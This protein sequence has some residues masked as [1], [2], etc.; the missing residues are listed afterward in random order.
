MKW[1]LGI[2]IGGEHLR[3]AVGCAEGEPLRAVRCDPLSAQPGVGR[4]QQQ[5]AEGVNS[6]L[7][8][9][10]VTREQ[11]AG[12]GVAAVGLVDLAKGVIPTGSG[13][14]GGGL[15]PIVDWV[16]KEFSWSAVLH[17][18]AAAA[19]HAEETFGAGRGA[20]P[21]LYVSADSEIEGALIAGGTI[22]C[23]R[24]G[25]GMSI[26]E[27]RPGVMPW[28]VA[29]AA[30]TVNGIASAWGVENRA[31]QA[32]VEWEQATVFIENRFQ[33]AGN[34]G[35][36]P[37]ASVRGGAERFATLL[38]LVQNDRRRITLPIIAQAASQGDRLSL[39]L[40][41]DAADTLGWA[42][43]QSVN[44]LS[45]TRIVVGGS[46]A[47]ID[48]ELFLEPLRKACRAEVFKPFETLVEIVPGALGENAAV[49]G[50]LALAAESFG[51]KTALRPFSPE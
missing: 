9:A 39:D 26:G 3:I 14:P 48:Q 42:L 46:I 38:K 17:N 37:S 12:V 15:F 47:R 28:R 16:R 27:M 20:D 36:P 50:V 6:L 33:V 43:A 18:A 24:G 25:G 5:I 13:G 10:R 29:A 45:P 51:E 32:I 22:Y 34:P 21:L 41:S 11:I 7:N 49:Q 30:A 2:E 1:C 31:R 4:L 40:L 8:Q 44:L 35:A 23:G 19:A